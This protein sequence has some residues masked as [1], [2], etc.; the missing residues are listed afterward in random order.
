M[1]GH[2]DTIVRELVWP[3]GAERGTIGWVSGRGLE[4]KRVIRAL[5]LHTLVVVLLIAGA[6][7]AWPRHRPAPTAKPLSELHLRRLLVTTTERVVGFGCGVVS[8]SGTG[9]AMGD[10]TLLTNRHVV[11]G[12]LGINVVPDLGPT[13]GGTSRVSQA[14]DVAVVR[15]S[16]TVP[17][18][19]RLAQQDVGP[20]DRVWLG[21]FPAQRGLMVEQA[22]VVDYVDGR[23]RQQAGRVMRVAA[24]LEPGMSGSPVLDREGRLAG[25]VFA[26]EETSGYG[27]VV[28]ASTIADVL[29]HA[30]LVPATSCR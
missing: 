20:G 18:R 15:P 10:G 21:G 29:A 17:S 2:P 4:R 1:N 25:L 5:S 14:V 8:S 27:L 19:I 11:D 23:P 9:V 12:V 28:P 13:A 24:H 22:T 16:R 26:I 7:A 3:F 30:P 6:A